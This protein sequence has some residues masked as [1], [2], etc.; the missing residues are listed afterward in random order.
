MDNINSPKAKKAFYKTKHF[1]SMLVI[2]FLLII[3]FSASILVSTLLFNQATREYR[4]TIIS[5]TAKLAAEQLDADQ[6]DQWLV[7]GTDAS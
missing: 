7:S 3:A 4:E 2:V 6:I 5:N 1:R